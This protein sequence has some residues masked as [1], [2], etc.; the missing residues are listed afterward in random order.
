MLLTRLADDTISPS[1]IAL[2]LVQFPL[3]GVIVDIAR[4]Y[5]RLVRAGL[6][7]LAAH[8]VAAGLCL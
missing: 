3:Y 5:G 6:V 1:L 7:L 8:T 4:H 2:A